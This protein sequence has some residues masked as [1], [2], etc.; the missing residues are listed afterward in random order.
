MNSYAIISFDKYCSGSIKS[1]KSKKENLLF[2]DRIIQHH[3]CAKQLMDWRLGLGLILQTLICTA[4]SQDTSQMP[5]NLTTTSHNEYFFPRDVHLS[6]ASFNCTAQNGRIQYEWRKDGEVLHNTQYITVDN[7]VGILKFNQMQ[8]ENYGIYQCFASNT[9]GTALSKPFKIKESRLGTFPTSQFQEVRCKQFE[10]CKVQCRD[11]PRCLPVSQCRVEWKIG[12]GTKA[13]VEIN[14]RVEVDGDGDL[15]FLWTNTSDWTGERYR[16]GVWHEQL[17]TLVVGSETSLK[18]DNATAVPGVDPVLVLKENGKASNGE[19]GVLRCLF[20]G[21]PV[22]DI[23]WISPQNKIINNASK[24]EIS[25]FGRVLTIFQAE[26]ENEGTYTCKG[27]GRN[28]SVFFNVTSAPFLSGSNQMRDLI[29]PEGKEATFR[30]QAESLP[31]EEPPTPPAWKKNGVDLTTDGGKN[32]LR[33]KSQVLT[34]NN[35]Q[36]SD[37]GVYQCMSENSEGVLLKEAILQVIDPITIRKSP[38]GNYKI[39]PGD[40]LNLAVVADT[41]P[42]LT[43]QY[44]WTFTDQQ[45][46]EREIESNK[47]WK[48]SWSNNNLTIDVRQ[49]KEPSI[50]H[51]LVG[52]YSVKV[53]HNYDQKVIN[54]T[55]ETDIITMETGITSTDITTTDIVNTESSTNILTTKVTPKT[56]IAEETSSNAAVYIIV[57]V[58]L[59]VIVVVIVVVVVRRIQQKGY[60]MGKTKAAIGPD[61]DNELKENPYYDMSKVEY[62]RSPVH[63]FEYEKAVIDKAENH[64]A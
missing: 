9:H 35:V 63:N 30:C 33:E 58:L 57:S 44:K 27:G 54:I 10:H 25:N 37:T 19:K 56:Y 32:M 1:E 61:S 23:T 24:Y 64:E 20:S 52:C 21:Y 47:Y 38:L 3:L 22:P 55:V 11:K 7:S 14:K 48:I 18:I 5:P 8:N 29:V 45:G 16:C 28:G 2:F 59:I 6:D 31:N 17:N 46:N 43:L 42:S 36:T 41:D 34:V 40:V 12:M 26:Q 39:V 62:E 13:S 53:Y 49:V 60:F 4:I 15:H 50:L 51:S